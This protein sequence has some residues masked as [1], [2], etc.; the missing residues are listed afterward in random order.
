LSQALGGDAIEGLER[1][2]GGASR[3]TWRFD[4]VAADGGRRELILR[5]DPPQ[6]P[7]PEGAMRREA[8]ALTA[9]RRAG[10]AVPEVV[11]ADGDGSTLGSPGMVMGRVEGETIAR[12]ILRDDEY[13]AARSR[14]ARQCGDFL[15]RLHQ[16]PVASVTG[17][18][19]EDAVTAY[20]G[21]YITLAQPSATFELAF[22][23]LEDN[24]PAG[25]GETI[26]H[27]D[28]RL[29]N[30]IVDEGGL[31]AVLDWEL[32]H[33]GDP[34]EDLGW[35]CTKAWRFGAE[36][37]VAGV[38]SREELVE[39]YEAAGG[40][41]V[42]PGTLA[43]WEVVGTLKWGVIC[44][45]QASV[46]LSGLHRSLELAAIGRRVCEQEADLLELLVPEQW[47][48]ALTDAQVETQ[49]ETQVEAGTSTPTPAPGLHGR[50][51]AVE[52]LDAL[53]GWLDTDV[54]EATTGRV[55]F[56]TKVASRVVAMIAREITLGPDQAARYHEGLSRLGVADEG[57]LAQAVAAGNLDGRRDEMVAF[58]CRSVADK[59]IVAHP[60]A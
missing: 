29:G 28:F 37:P 19:P 23:W 45:G 24:R 53:Q 35:L 47:A 54:S 26:V 36:H 27:G 7:G 8:E 43:W 32:V 57:E 52:L 20:R 15:G 58:L 25:T 11:V 48:K 30:L 49:V 39:A 56:H 44:M 12:R 59:L 10:L 21:S 2:S 42:D 17:L 40:A 3:E 18:A 55:R 41:P 9:S 33:K 6:R 60:P 14:L 46:H 31:A 13:R 16:L 22:R 34:I 38:G 5:R 1:L 4:A 51:T 50:P